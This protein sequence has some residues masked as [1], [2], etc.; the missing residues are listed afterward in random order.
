MT[1]QDPRPDRRER[2][3]FVLEVQPE[4]TRCAWHAWLR[5]TATPAPV[6]ADFDSPLALLR[7][8]AHLHPLPGPTGSGGLR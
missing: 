7:Y 4:T 8:L 1:P 2:L 5:S 6:L 3:L